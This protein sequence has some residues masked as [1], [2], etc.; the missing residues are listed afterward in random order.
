MTKLKPATV[1]PHLRIKSA[2]ALAVPPVAIK[3][4]PL[5]E[6]FRAEATALWLAAGERVARVYD[7]DLAR[8][9]MVLERIVPG[10]QLREVAMDDEAATRLAAETVATAPDPEA[11]YNSALRRA[12]ESPTPPTIRALPL[13]SSVAE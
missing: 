1:P 3:S 7:V 4:S 9:V 5:A 2:A 11:K 10:T 13:L 6:E 12:I 8:G